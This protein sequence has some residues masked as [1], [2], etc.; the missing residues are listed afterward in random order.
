MCSRSVV[1]LLLPAVCRS[2]RQGLRTKSS[3]GANQLTRKISFLL[4]PLSRRHRMGKGVHLL[5]GAEEYVGGGS[6]GSSFRRRVY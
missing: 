4:C 5:Q 6:I 2:F 1:I 3:S